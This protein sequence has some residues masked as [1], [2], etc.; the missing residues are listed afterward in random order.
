MVFFQY[1]D[2]PGVIGRV[3]TLFGEAGINIANM[4]VSRTNE[5]GKALMALSIDTPAPPRTRRG[6]AARPGSTT[7]ASSAWAD[8]SRA[9]RVT[10][11]SSSSYVRSGSWSSTGCVDQR[12]LRG[13]GARSGSSASSPSAKAESATIA[14]PS[15]SW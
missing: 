9:T 5:G 14:R 6:A 2:R 12:L 13:L 3:G 15:P 4:A 8:A 1:D 10:T 7:P 11:V